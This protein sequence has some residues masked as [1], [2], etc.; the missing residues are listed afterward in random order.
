MDI[1]Y[2][3]VE[4]LTF[5]ESPT[6]RK[7]LPTNYDKSLSLCFSMSDSCANYNTQWFISILQSVS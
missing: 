1:N 7:P 6:I 2:F 3:H 5:W 4:N